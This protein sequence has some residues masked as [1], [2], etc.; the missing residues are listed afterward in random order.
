M[1]DV[2]A[3]SEAYPGFEATSWAMMAVPKGTPDPLRE[4]IAGVLNNSMNTPAVVQALATAGLEA[5]PGTSPA[6]AKAYALAEYAK[7]G[8]VIRKANIKI[9]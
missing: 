9:D 6:S 7:W 2:P 1:P 5:T 8:D 4:R 3:I